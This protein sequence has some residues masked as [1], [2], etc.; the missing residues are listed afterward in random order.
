[1]QAS[2]EARMG[3]VADIEE[4]SETSQDPLPKPARSICAAVRG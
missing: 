3:T 2:N 4:T 1:M